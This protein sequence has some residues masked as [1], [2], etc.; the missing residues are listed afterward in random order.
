MS[1]T[2]KRNSLELTET[3][4]IIKTLSRSGD[5]SVKQIAEDLG[6]SYTL[7]KAVLVGTSR[8][9]F[10]CDRLFSIAA[11]TQLT[12]K[13]M[14]IKKMLDLN[15]TNK[16]LARIFKVSKNRVSEAIHEAR[17]HKVNLKKKLT[18]HI[19]HLYS[20]YLHEKKITQSKNK[21]AILLKQKNITLQDLAKTTDTDIS[22]VSY[23]IN[24]RFNI[25]KSPK[26]RKTTG[27]IAKHAGKPANKLWQQ[28][29]EN[30]V[31]TLFRLHQHGETI[32]A[33]A[34]KLNVNHKTVRRVVLNQIQSTKGKKAMAVAQYIAQVLN[35]SVEDLWPQLSYTKASNI[36][37]VGVANILNISPGQVSKALL[38][39][40]AK[41][42]P[43]YIKVKRYVKKHYNCDI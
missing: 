25:L 13:Q 32:T 27:I 23:L 36:S 19:E 1:Y 6:R 11:N 34:E 2:E 35:Q 15:L 5:I 12:E 30:Q 17:G 33:V 37:R 40:Y 8:N 26:L 22:T 10:I 38:G 7:V 4:N 43:N 29:S 16:D 21:I 28:F 3:R 41:Q 14:L 18:A 20:H 9:K 31:D 42:N 24:G 39:Q